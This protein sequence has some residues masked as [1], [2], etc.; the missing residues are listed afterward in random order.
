LP[1]PADI[2]IEATD[3]LNVFSR[4]GRRCRLEGRRR[5][6]SLT[7]GSLSRIGCKIW[8]G[9]PELCRRVGFD[10]TI[11]MIR[12]R[13]L[14]DERLTGPR[15]GLPLRGHVGLHSLSGRIRAL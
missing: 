2:R 3:W 7:I 1:F 14:H 9:L 12:G 11:G 10:R 13:F 8:G 5:V 4:G 15:Y 6:N